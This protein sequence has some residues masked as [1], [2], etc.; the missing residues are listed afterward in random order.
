MTIATT[1]GWR[2]SLLIRL[3]AIAIRLDMFL[4]PIDYQSTSAFSVVE[5]K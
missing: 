1:V 3:E 4:R 5:L 2:T